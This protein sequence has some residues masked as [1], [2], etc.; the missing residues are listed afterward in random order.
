MPTLD[1]TVSAMRRIMWG[2]LVGLAALTAGCSAK[3]ASGD[4]QAANAVSNQPSIG[5][6]SFK[7]YNEPHPSP[8]PSCD[9]FTSLETWDEQGAKARLEERLAGTCEIYVLPRTRVYE[10]ALD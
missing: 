9:V 1:H 2:V 7:L 6:A 4:D 10:L 5:K 8:D 3:S